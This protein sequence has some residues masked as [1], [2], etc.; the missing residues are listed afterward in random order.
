MIS[1]YYDDINNLEP[2]LHFFPKWIKLLYTII[3]SPQVVH[4]EIG[5]LLIECAM[6]YD[7]LQPSLKIKQRMLMPNKLGVMGGHMRMV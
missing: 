4:F 1:W 6:D 7:V 3:L 5:H 2:Q